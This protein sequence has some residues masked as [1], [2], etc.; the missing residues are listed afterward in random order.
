[1][2]GLKP[3][4]LSLPVVAMDDVE[5]RCP[6][7]L[8]A[9]VSKFVGSDR[10][11]DHAPILTQHCGVE[12]HAGRRFVVLLPVAQSGNTKCWGRVPDRRL[13]K[14]FDPRNGTNQH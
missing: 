1:M 8:A 2:D 12:A 4:C 6:E 10:L 5:S 3:I 14:Q 7:Y 11:K 13:K 9:E